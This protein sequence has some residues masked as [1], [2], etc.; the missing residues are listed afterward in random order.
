MGQVSFYRFKS[1]PLE[2]KFV[3]PPER[4][5]LDPYPSV[6]MVPAV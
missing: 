3:T 4:K 6:D 1:T 2:K 5:I